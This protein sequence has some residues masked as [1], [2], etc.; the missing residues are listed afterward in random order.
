MAGTATLVPP[1]GLV[2]SNPQGTDKK[3]L[4]A[5]FT[6]DWL[7]M[8]SFIAQTMQLPI[9]Q[10]N[11]EDKY[12]KFSSEQDIADVVA[13]MAKIQGLSAQ[14]G[15]PQKLIDELKND[16]TI[17]QSPNPPK[18]LYIYIVWF[19]TKLYEAANSYHQTLG[20]F[21]Q[22]LN[23]SNCGTPAECGEV[24]KT[25]LTGQGGLQS[26]AAD[27]VTKTNALIQAMAGFEQ[28]LKPAVDEMATYTSDDATFMKEVEADIGQDATDIKTYTTAAA[29]AYKS[30]EDY[31]IA[32]VTV[33]LG[34]MIFSGG[35][36]W[37]AAAV[38][39]GVL[40]HD[41][42]EAREAYDKAES[43]LHAA[44]KDKQQ[45]MTLKNDLGGLNHSMPAASAA[46][47]AFLK[48]LQEVMGVWENTAT[49]IAYIA[50][51]FTV[52]KLGDLN[53]VMQA[54]DLH[55]ATEDWQ[56]IAAATQEYTASSLVTYTL[57]DFGAK[58][59]S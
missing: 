51:N 14:F 9:T 59:P 31:T 36:A 47:S 20:D 55:K 1:A 5:L 7:R 33:S 50:D 4:F 16:P 42:V 56:Q 12:G 25:I 2:V 37:P 58:L 38:A 11:F 24:L 23:P 18:E 53:W 19:A 54:L 45:K 44:E 52:E 22:L 13:A 49:N 10:G 29:A 34:L 48:K 15:D 40:G 39:A 57:L 21:E 6:S 41:A 8:Q 46:A 27:M 43:N 17:L 28:Q 3:P 35:L 32:A 26:T 30:W